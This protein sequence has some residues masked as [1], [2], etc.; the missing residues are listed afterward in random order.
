VCLEVVWGLEGLAN[1]P[2]VVNLSID[3]QG[4]AVILVGKRLS[5]ALCVV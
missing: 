4:D 1:D 5:S 3:G 2:V